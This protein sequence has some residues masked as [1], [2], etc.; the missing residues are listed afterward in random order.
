MFY[1]YHV[2]YNNSNYFLVI[3]CLACL[4]LF[5]KILFF[6]YSYVLIFA[7][8]LVFTRKTATGNINQ[9]SIM[10][11]LIPNDFLACNIFTCIS[12]DFKKDYFLYYLSFCTNLQEI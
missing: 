8:L 4:S 1:L 6:R 7:S 3:M 11:R 12:R 10:I 5:Q 2:F 9:H